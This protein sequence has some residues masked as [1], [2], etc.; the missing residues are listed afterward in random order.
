[1]P[2]AQVFQVPMEF[3][4]KFMPVIGANCID[5]EREFSNDIIDEVDSI[6]LCMLFINRARIRV[7]SSIAVY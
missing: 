1:V 5:P 4:L 3:D 7:A 6:L 2:Y